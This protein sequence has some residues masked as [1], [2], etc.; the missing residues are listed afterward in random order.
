MAL[1]GGEEYRLYFAERK[2]AHNLS[3]IPTPVPHQVGQDKCFGRHFIMIKLHF[4]QTV[5][6]EYELISLIDFHKSIPFHERRPHFYET[7]FH[8][9]VCCL[10]PFARL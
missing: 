10:R 9:H 3:Y 2:R 8:L 6:T 7:D 5:C 4:F 1:A